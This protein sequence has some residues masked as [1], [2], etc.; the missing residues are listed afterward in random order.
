[1]LATSLSGEAANT[2]FI[3]IGLTRQWLEP[4]IVSTGGEL[5]NHC[6]AEAVYPTCTLVVNNIGKKLTI[7]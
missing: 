4:I 3:V 5:A 2:N 6:I 7:S 1:M